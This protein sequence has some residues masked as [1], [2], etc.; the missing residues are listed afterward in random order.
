MSE[1]GRAS[2]SLAATGSTSRSAAR[3]VTAAGSSFYAPG[4]ASSRT[5]I[6]RVDGRG[7]TP[8]TTITTTDDSSLVAKG[9]TG[10]SDSSGTP[11]YWQLVLPDFE[12]SD[13]D[14]DCAPFWT[15]YNAADWANAPSIVKLDEK[16]TRAAQRMADPFEVRM[17][18]SGQLQHLNASVV[19]AQKAAQ[20]ALKYKDMSED[21]HSCI[22]EQLEKVSGCWCG[23]FVTFSSPELSF[24]VGSYR[25]Q[26]CA[27]CRI[28]FL[29]GWHQGMRVRGIDR[30]LTSSPKTRIP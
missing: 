16:K 7:S 22:L 8:R 2:C 14:E 1:K 19:S 4:S 26:V 28:W 3:S 13:L 29:L 15:I 30:G 27:A 10:S 24:W 18:F 20:Y 5:P 17:R 25:E 9:S 12:L 6:T 23:I 11:P 21:L